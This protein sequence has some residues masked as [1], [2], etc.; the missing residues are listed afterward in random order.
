MDDATHLRAR[1]TRNCLIGAVVVLS[2]LLA[3][4]GTWAAFLKRAVDFPDCPAPTPPLPPVPSDLKCNGSAAEESPKGEY[5]VVKINPNPVVVLGFR[6]PIS[7]CTFNF[8]ASSQ[9]VSFSLSVGPLLGVTTDVTCATANWSLD[10]NCRVAFDMSKGCMPE[11]VRKYKLALKEWVYD[12]ENDRVMGII[13]V[14]TTIVGV[15]ADV[16]IAA[17]L[18]GG[19]PRHGGAASPGQTPAAAPTPAPGV[20]CP[21]C[22]A[23]CPSFNVHIPFTDGQACNRMCLHPTVGQR[24]RSTSAQ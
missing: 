24:C 10:A 5:T 23:A 11:L 15:H 2:M 17:E 7:R 3:A 22:S 18:Q 20:T 21:S 1:R 6:V 19:Q 16:S 4:I 12:A 14:H 9:T 8:D 13:A